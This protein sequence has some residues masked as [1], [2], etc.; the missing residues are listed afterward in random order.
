VPARPVPEIDIRALTDGE[1]AA[2]GAVAGRALCDD[3]LVEFLHG[4]DVLDRLR[5]SYDM[6]VGT[7]LA[8]PEPALGAFLGNHPVAIVA[9][10]PPDTCFMG[11]LDPA[12]RVP[13]DGPLGAPGSPDRL[14]RAMANW[15]EHHTDERHWHVGPVSVEPH[16]QGRGVGSLVMQRFCERMDDE[17]EMAWLETERPENVVFYRRLGFDVMSESDVHTLHTWFMQRPPR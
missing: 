2:G 9:A 1:R 5:A 6:F 4:D 17:G 15:C 8:M 11:R 16:L 13:P 12:M 10:S 7:V 3:P 14:R